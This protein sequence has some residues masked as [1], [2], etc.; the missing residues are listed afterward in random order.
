[1]GAEHAGLIV[2]DIDGTLIPA[3]LRWLRRAVARTYAIAENAVVFLT[4]RVHGYTDEQCGLECGDCLSR[5]VEKQPA[6]PLV[7]LQARGVPVAEKP[8][9]VRFADLFHRPA[10]HH[11]CV[12]TLS[13][14]FQHGV[15]LRL[16]GGDSGTGC[17]WQSVTEH[18]G[19]PQ[20]SESDH[21]VTVRANQRGGIGPQVAFEDPREPAYQGIPSLSARRRAYTQLA[22]AMGRSPTALYRRLATIDVSPSSAPSRASARSL[23][24]ARKSSAT[25]SRCAAMRPTKASGAMLCL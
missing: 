25:E 4:A 19:L 11:K 9:S 13:R 16:L 24:A 18:G 22:N 20:Y 14:Q 12:L 1:M 5:L 6:C 3:D 21:D 15:S 8:G 23:C 17:G 10:S 2:W 7:H